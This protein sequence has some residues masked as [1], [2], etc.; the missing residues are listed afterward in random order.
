MLDGFVDRDDI[1]EEVD[2]VVDEVALL[3]FES[4]AVVRTSGFTDPDSSGDNIERSMLLLSST[5]S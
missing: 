1:D 3:A 2:V 4:V 5:E